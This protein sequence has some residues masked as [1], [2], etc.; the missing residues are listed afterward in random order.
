MTVGPQRFLDALCS[1][2]IGETCG[3]VA[4]NFFVFFF[5]GLVRGVVA[6]AAGVVDTDLVRFG[7]VNAAVAVPLDVLPFLLLDCRGLVRIGWPG[8]GC[9]G[10]R[11][12]ASATY[13]LTVMAAMISSSCLASAGVF[14]TLA[15]ETAK[16][17]LIGS[18]SS[19]EAG[20]VAIF[21]L[22]LPLPER[23]GIGGSSSGSSSSSYLIMCLFPGFGRGLDGG[24]LMFFLRLILCL[25]R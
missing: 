19:L 14:V 22:P 1:L 6:G 11:V 9:G 10:V 4:D 23:T 18:V 5:N 21:F 16:S 25:C 13:P 7:G 24:F 17:A 2:P 3:E 8:V 15:A 20:G 12:D